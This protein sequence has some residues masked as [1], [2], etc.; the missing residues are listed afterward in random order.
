[1]SPPI[2]EHSFPDLWNLMQIRQEVQSSRFW[3]IVRQPNHSTSLQQSCLFWRSFI[4]L[5]L[6]F[7]Q[8]WLIVFSMNTTSGKKNPGKNQHRISGQKYCISWEK[9]KLCLACGPLS[10]C[11]SWWHSLTGR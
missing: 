9:L 5:Q 11:L 2:P 1:S 6:H 7:S 10:C 8:S 3:L 4:H